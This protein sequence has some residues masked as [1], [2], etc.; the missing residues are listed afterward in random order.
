MF[1]LAPIRE[2]GPLWATRP[3][4]SARA[5]P[6]IHPPEKAFIT[7]ERGEER[8]DTV[9]ERNAIHIPLLFFRIYVSPGPHAS[10]L[11]P[12]RIDFL[13]ERGGSHSRHRRGGKVHFR[14]DRGQNTTIIISSYWRTLAAVDVGRKQARE[15]RTN[16]S[17]A[18]H[19]RVPFYSYVPS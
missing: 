2:Q 19:A 5:F 3:V 8:K 18:T 7:T 17:K 11:R 6:M 13:E 4:H 1:E 10:Q 14:P 9:R 12:T 16:R 15:R